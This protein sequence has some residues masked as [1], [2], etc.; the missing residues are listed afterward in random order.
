MALEYPAYGVGM[1]NFENRVGEYTPSGRDDSPHNNIIGTLAETG[2]TGALLY[3]TLFISAIFMAAFASKH[4]SEP[5]LR[6]ISVFLAASLVAYFTGGM[7]MTRHTMTLA[8]L[9]AGG[10]L[11]VYTSC[12]VAPSASTIQTPPE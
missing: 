8:Y 3:L 2:F 7:F 12:T 6:E 10:A 5:E 11:A 9:L 1:G 4:S